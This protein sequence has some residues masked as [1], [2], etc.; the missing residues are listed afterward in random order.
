[1]ADWRDDP[2]ILQ[3]ATRKV[4]S[5]GP[6]SAVLAR[7]LHHLD[8]PVLRWSDG[9]FSAA[10][11]VAGLPIISLT[12]TGA[13]SGQAR[14]VPLIAIP[15]GQRLILVASNW[16]RPKH[17]AWYHNL[18]ANPTATATVGGQTAVWIAR[19]LGGAEREAAWQRA[20]ALYPGYAEYARR[21]GGRVIPVLALERAGAATDPT[22][23]P[24]SPGRRP[25]Q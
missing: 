15:D 24:G 3:R 2:N 10:S 8:G 23:S 5:L 6:V 21:N 13:K 19:E 17:P 1:M 22:P 12:T 16:G 25:S 11:L 7:T 18:R 9:R 4:V 20:V 14:T